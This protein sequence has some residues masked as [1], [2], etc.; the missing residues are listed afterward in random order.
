MLLAVSSVIKASK[1]SLRGLSLSFGPKVDML[2]V[3]EAVSS[4]SSLEVLLLKIPYHDLAFS[5]LLSCLERTC[6]ASLNRLYLKF[7]WYRKSGHEPTLSQLLRLDSILQ[8]QHHRSLEMISVIR[9]GI[10]A[11]RFSW[12]NVYRD[13]V[14]D[15]DLWHPLVKA[16]LPKTFER[17]VLAIWDDDDISQEP[18]LLNPH[19]PMPELPTE[20]N[21]R[22]INFVAGDV[23]SARTLRACAATCR[24]WKLRSQAHLFRSLRVVSSPAHVNGVDNLVTLLRQ[25]EALQSFA[26]T[27]DAV[28]GEEDYPTLQNILLSLAGLL[29]RLTDISLARGILYRPPRVSF[30]TC[31][32]TFATVRNLTLHTVTLFSGRDL[33]EVIAGLSGLEKLTLTHLSWHDPTAHSTFPTHRP[34]I[35]PLKELFI[36]ADTAQW[37]RDQR[38]ANLVRWLANCGAVSTLKELHLDCMMILEAGLLG[39]VQNLVLAAKDTLQLACLSLG[40]DMELLQMAST[41]A[42]CP[43]L[44]IIGLRLPYLLHCFAPLTTFIESLPANSTEMLIL[45]LLQDRSTEAPAISDWHQLDK[46]LH[47]AMEDK[48]LPQLG[49]IAVGKLCAQSDPRQPLVWGNAYPPLSYNEKRWQEEL[50]SLMPHM[51]KRQCLSSIAKNGEI[52]PILPGLPISP[53]DMTY[54]PFQ[55]ITPPPPYRY[56]DNIACD[57]RWEGRVVTQT[58]ILPCVQTLEDGTEVSTEITLDMPIVV[59][60]REGVSSQPHDQCTVA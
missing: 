3:A 57:S 55:K 35:S 7:D 4:C 59:V 5:S 31:T 49:R 27:L 39:A 16:A 33:Q 51:S 11:H 8:A 56:Q 17:G 44:R 14:Y 19:L 21:E 52:L 32:Q 18:S 13:Q 2:P 15:L 54:A 12:G 47:D 9:V 22:I 23:D 48:K 53:W 41:I 45:S 50:S 1:N 46:A 43:S 37:L 29:P 26:R 38:S 24:S 40:P 42:Q 36:G 30:K 6:A 25:N 60:P 28:G 10:N 20:V 58:I 34:Q